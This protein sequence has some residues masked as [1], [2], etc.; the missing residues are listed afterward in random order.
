M[1][2][3]IHAAEVEAEFFGFGGVVEDEIATQEAAGDGVLGVAVT[4]GDII[5]K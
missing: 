4:V 5:L 1:L 3:E 2:S